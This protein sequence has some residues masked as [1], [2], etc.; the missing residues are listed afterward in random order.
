[1]AR[2]KSRAAYLDFTDAYKPWDPPPEGYI[3]RQEWA[4]VQYR[5]GLRQ[6][7]CPGCGLW[8]F[9][10]ETCCGD[11]AGPETRPCPS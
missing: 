8:R 5:A 10:Q 4:G 11:A 1:M 6:R 3:A 9:P 2:A 7:R